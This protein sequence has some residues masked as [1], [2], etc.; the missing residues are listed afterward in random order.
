MS[1]YDQHILE[2]LRDGTTTNRKNKS[3]ATPPGVTAPFV[4]TRL[5]DTFGK[6]TPCLLETINHLH[7]LCEEGKAVR[8]SFGNLGYY[9]LVDYQPPRKINVA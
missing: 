9:R 7:R 6:D 1:K 4:M 3:S 2:A 8:S 5:R